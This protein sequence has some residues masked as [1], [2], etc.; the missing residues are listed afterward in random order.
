MFPKT[1]ADLEPVT[2]SVEEETDVAPI[3]VDASHA[4]PVKIMVTAPSM[5]EASIKCVPPVVA[6]NHRT[7]GGM[8]E[9][10]KEQT[11]PALGKP[12]MVEPL[13]MTQVTEVFR[14][15]RIDC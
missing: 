7:V 4:F 9:T 10:R 2:L 1:E 15:Y 13:V 12:V 11:I 8:R 6:G 14:T 3:T 5:A